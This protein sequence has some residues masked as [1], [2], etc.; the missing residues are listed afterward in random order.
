M[1]GNTNF[2]SDLSSHAVTG[3]LNTVD[4]PDPTVRSTL[5]SSTQES[6]GASGGKRHSMIESGS[7]TSGEGASGRERS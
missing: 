5:I 4:P 6:S 7:Q 2:L 1:A 3:L